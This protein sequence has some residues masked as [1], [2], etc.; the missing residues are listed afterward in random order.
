[1]IFQI[2][3]FHRHRQ[4][5]QQ[6][7]RIRY[8]VR[9]V[10]N[11]IP[12]C[13]TAMKRRH[14]VPPVKTR[15][16]LDFVNIRSILPFFAASQCTSWKKTASVLHEGTHIWICKE[17]RRSTTNQIPKEVPKQSHHLHFSIFNQ[18]LYSVENQIADDDIAYEPTISCCRLQ[19][20]EIK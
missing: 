7:H 1:M 12:S 6:C 19:A 8:K 15:I 16:F 3:Q 4:T 10:L 11:H 9:Q 2:S 13:V 18:P 20:A 14:T 5:G 17:Y